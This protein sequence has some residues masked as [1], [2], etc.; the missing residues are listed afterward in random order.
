MREQAS[1]DLAKLGAA[2]VPFV[3]RALNDPDEEIRERAENLLKNVEGTDARTAQCVA[4]ARLLR[5]R[6]PAVAA[7]AVLGRLPDGGNG[8]AAEET[9]AVLAGLAGQQDAAVATLLAYVPD[10]ETNAVED[11]VTASLAVLAVHDGKVDA[12]VVAALKDKSLSRRAAAAV[13]V[14]RSGTVEQ[15][16]AVQ[17]L[18]ADPDPRIRFRAAQGLLAGRD[19]IAVPALVALVK[20]GPP[21]LALQAS[22]LLSCAVGVH[23]PHTPYGDDA[24]SR[25]NCKKAWADWSQKNAKTVD[26][27]RADVDLPPL[28]PALRARAVVRQCFNALVQHDL[29]AFKKTCDVPFHMFAEPTRL[30]RDDLD[31]L[32][33]ENPIGVQMQPFYP[34]LVA[35]RR[36]KSS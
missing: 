3:R 34:L 22:E 36:C 14:G 6:A 26:L 9:M 19:R 8:F 12:A 5:R 33:N 35:R 18:L 2:A 27:S 13:V 29:A 20:D 32:F 17:A 25:Q 31:G 24:A 4:A 11:D 1:A 30:K 7:A 10:V 16:V 23:A 21:D 28:N 15:R